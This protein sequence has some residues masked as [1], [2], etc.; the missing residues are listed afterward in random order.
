MNFGTK[1]NC[2]FNGKNKKQPGLVPKINTKYIVLLPP[3]DDP[4]CQLPIQF[5]LTAMLLWPPLILVGCTGRRIQPITAVLH[6]AAPGK[7]MHP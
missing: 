2:G 5:L 1:F 6:D 4:H 3:E 7:E